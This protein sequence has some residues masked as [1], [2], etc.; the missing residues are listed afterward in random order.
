MRL[1]RPASGVGV[2]DVLGAVRSE[3]VT[4]SSWAGSAELLSAVIRQLAARGVAAAA[5]R[6]AQDQCK[7]Q[8]YAREYFFIPITSPFSLVETAG[9]YLLARAAVYANASRGIAPLSPPARVRTA[10]CARL[11]LLVADDEHIRVSFCSG[12]RG[13]CSRSFHCAGRSSTRTPAGLEAS[14]DLLGP[15]GGCGP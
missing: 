2:G 15:V 12:P 10:T 6:E 9:P 14:R 4:P 8:Q 13:S 11:G 1:R 7:R 5:G 3:G